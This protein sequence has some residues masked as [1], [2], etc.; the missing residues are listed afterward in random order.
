MW[1][2][3]LRLMRKESFLL[4]AFLLASSLMLASAF[5]TE[6]VLEGDAT[7]LDWRIIRLF[8]DPADPSLPLGPAWLQ[9]A[10]RDITSLGSTVV[11][12]TIVIVVVLYL[13]LA[14]R[15]AAALLLLIAVMGG[16]IIS[17]LGKLAIDRPRPE[18]PDWAPRVVTA[19]FPSG[20]AMLS[21][22]TY[23]TLGA[24]LARVEVRT[25]LRVYFVC[26]AILL[27]ISVGV[28]RVYLGVHWPSD[29]LAGWAVGSAWAL[30]CW[31]VAIWLQ[32]RGNV[33]RPD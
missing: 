29:V 15:R 25:T 1:N 7:R 19:S 16:Q 26:V 20:H 17:T 18:L 6:E 11:L 30:I 14:G 13:V 27:T 3:A 28:S 5:V 12:S 9:E 21:A 4:L 8:R 32:R 24:L 33:E 22:V 10:M 2:S 23:L 31:A